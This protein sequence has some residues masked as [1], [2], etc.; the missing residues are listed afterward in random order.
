MLRALEHAELSHKILKSFCAE[1]HLGEQVLGTPGGDRHQTSLHMTAHQLIKKN[2]KIYIS[3]CESK[4]KGFEQRYLIC[5][6]F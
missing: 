1:S 4:K 6:F 5:F 2:S 3:K